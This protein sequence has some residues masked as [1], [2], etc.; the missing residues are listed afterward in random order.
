MGLGSHFLSATNKT[1][2][3]VTLPVPN[4]V[5]LSLHHVLSDTE[6]PPQ[7]LLRSLEQ[8]HTHRP[9]TYPPP[10]LHLASPHPPPQEAGER[11]EGGK[12]KKGGR[13]E[14]EKKKRMIK[15]A[16]LSRVD[17]LTFP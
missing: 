16:L 15:R 7:A 17:F 2:R 10:T 4:L 6:P 8:A 12:E 1:P 14:G 5:L 13:K 11:R 9:S 3:N